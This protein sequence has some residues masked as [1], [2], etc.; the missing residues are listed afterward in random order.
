MYNDNN[1]FYKIITGDI[2]ANIIIDNEKSLSF[3]DISPQAPIHA[4]VIPK[5]RYINAL[6]FCKNAS[7]DEMANFNKTVVDTIEKLK[8]TDGFRIISN[9]GINGGQEVNHYHIHIL[10]GKKLGKMLAD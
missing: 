4:L 9:T 1:I 7:L 10:A 8:I 3:Y 6:D 5:G 2:K